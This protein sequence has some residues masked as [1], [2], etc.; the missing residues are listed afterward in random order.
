MVDKLFRWFHSKR[1]YWSIIYNTFKFFELKLRLIIFYFQCVIYFIFLV[2]IYNYFKN[3]PKFYIFY[4]SFFCPL[5]IT[6]HVAELEILARKEILV[7]I[8]FLIFLLISENIKLKKFINVY[9]ILTLPLII[10]IWEPIIF[11]YRFIFCC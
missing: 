8:N 9:L 6:Y 1:S 2:L 3:L 4:L 7:F 5:F 11:F 10:L